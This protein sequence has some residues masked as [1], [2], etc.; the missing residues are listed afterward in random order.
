MSTLYPFLTEV[1]Y[2]L[3]KTRIDDLTDRIDPL[4][5]ENDQELIESTSREILELSEFLRFYY[6]EDK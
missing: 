2:S 3:V 6:E 4:N 1:I 5:G